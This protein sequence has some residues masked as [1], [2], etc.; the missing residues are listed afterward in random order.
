[1]LMFFYL[2]ITENTKNSVS[3]KKDIILALLTIVTASKTFLKAK[4]R[5]PLFIH[6]IQLI[7]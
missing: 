2:L 7:R 3:A 5:P 6:D 1:M 4:S